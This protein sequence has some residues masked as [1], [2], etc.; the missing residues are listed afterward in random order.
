[1][2]L[3]PFPPVILYRLHDLVLFP[4]SSHLGYPQEVQN[5]SSASLIREQ[6][7]DFEA[8][9]PPASTPSNLCPQSLLL[10]LPPGAILKEV[11]PGLD[12]AGAPPALR[13]GLI[14]RPLK[15]RQCPVFSW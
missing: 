1:M 2:N 12:F 8:I 3:A 5:C 4:P 11:L 14:L 6:V 15:V 9:L 7:S 10:Q 13:V